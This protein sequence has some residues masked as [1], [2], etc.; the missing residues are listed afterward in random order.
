MLI[1]N[2]EQYPSVG[3][4][5]L[6]TLFKL[7]DRLFQ[8]LY[9]CV[10]SLLTGLQIFYLLAETMHLCLGFILQSH[11]QGEKD[12]LFICSLFLLHVVLFVI[13]HWCVPI[14]TIVSSIEIMVIFKTKKTFVWLYPTNIG[15]K[16]KCIP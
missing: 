12:V 5:F 4:E 11:N 8:H 14:W 13:L 6:L 3:I 7:S 15:R 16:W 9:T 10:A 2:R 1:K